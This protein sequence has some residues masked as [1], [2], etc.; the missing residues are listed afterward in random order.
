EVVSLA[1]HPRV[2]AIGEIGLDFYREF[3][4]PFFQKKAFAAQLEAAASLNKPVILH[5]RE[6]FP[7]VFTALE[8][9]AGL[10]LVFHCFSGTTGEAQRAV[11]LGGY[12]SFAGNV[13]YKNAS[14]LQKA[15]AFVPLGRLLVE[16]DSP[17]LAPVPHRGK[18]NEPRLVVHVGEAV[19]AA[20]GI[21]VEEVARATTENAQSIFGIF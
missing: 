17:Y 14:S 2:V 6:S 4:D 9:V 11:D 15:A 21:E 8:A 13:S 1:A 7:E 12:V 20:R 18:S 19:A 16:T 10:R 3:A 5:I